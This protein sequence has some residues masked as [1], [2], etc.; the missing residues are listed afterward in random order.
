M[1]EEQLDV[2]DKAGKVI[3]TM[4]RSEAEHANHV[5]QNVLIFIFNPEDEVWIQLRPM[6]KKHFPG[7]WEISACGAVASGEKPLEAAKRETLEE[8]GLEPE[9][10][11]VETFLNQFPGHDN[12]TYSRL[13][14]L[15][16]AITEKEPKLTDEVDEFKAVNYKDLQQQIKSNPDKYV[17]SFLVE[18]EKAS[19]TFEKLKSRATSTALL[20]DDKID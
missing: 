17:P 3:G 15:F 6:H 14:H 11:Y 10:K 7:L 8:T 13:S 2:V 20:P 4:A 9:L 12:Q 1:Q 5:I 16:I 18:L 19:A